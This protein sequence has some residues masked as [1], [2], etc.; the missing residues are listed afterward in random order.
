MCRLGAC[1]RCCTLAIACALLLCPLG[2]WH[3]RWPAPRLLMPVR[4]RSGLLGRSLMGGL[5]VVISKPLNV[6]ILI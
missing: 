2:G 4:V 5:A 3:L 1:R 6:D